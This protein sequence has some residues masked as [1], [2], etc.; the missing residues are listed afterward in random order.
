MT[1]MTADQST[2]FCDLDV[3]VFI[4]VPFFKLFDEYFEVGEGF[5]VDEYTSL[6]MF[7]LGP[8]VYPYPFPFGYVTDLRHHLAET[9]RP[10]HSERVRSRGYQK[11]R[12][13]KRLVRQRLFERQNDL[14]PHRL[15]LSR[16]SL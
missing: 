7:R 3:E 2:L 1:S 15:P 5:E 4:V 9:G 6:A 10:R 14:S 12:I 11:L 13:L 8:H 16:L